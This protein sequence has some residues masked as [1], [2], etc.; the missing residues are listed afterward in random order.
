MSGVIPLLPLHTPW[1]GQG[2]LPLRF[3]RHEKLL[4]CFIEEMNEE[5]SRIWTKIYLKIRAKL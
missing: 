1:R 4:Q 3:P 5:L 2:K